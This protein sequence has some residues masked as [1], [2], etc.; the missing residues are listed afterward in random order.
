AAFAARCA[1]RREYGEP[2][3]A[4][5]TE[6]ASSTCLRR[7][8]AL[9][10]LWSWFTLR[11]DRAEVVG[12]TVRLPGAVTKNGKPLS[13]ALEGPLLDVIRR[14]YTCRVPESPYVFHPAGRRIARFDAAWAAARHAAGL[15]RLPLPEL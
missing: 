7:C 14:R 11:L 6:S 13:L 9:G 12:G 8:N 15:P 1:K 5:A 2:G 4:A 10:A 3:V